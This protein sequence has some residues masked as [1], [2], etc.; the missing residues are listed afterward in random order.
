MAMVYRRV[1]DRIAAV[2]MPWRQ[3]GARRLRRQ[4]APILLHM[5]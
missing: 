4:I 3:Q 1:D 5:T 2:T